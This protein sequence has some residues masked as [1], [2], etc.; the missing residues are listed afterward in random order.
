MRPFLLFSALAFFL[1]AFFQGDPNKQK[2]SPWKPR[3]CEDPC[4]SCRIDSMERETRWG[5]ATPAQYESFK[6]DELL[7]I[8]SK[9]NSCDTCGVER[10][11]GNWCAPRHIDFRE[12]SGEWS[13]W[14]IEQQ[15]NGKKCDILPGSEKLLFKVTAPEQANADRE[16]F[17]FLSTIQQDDILPFEDKFYKW[18][19]KEFKVDLISGYADESIYPEKCIHGGDL[20][21]CPDFAYLQDSQNMIRNLSY[22]FCSVVP[23]TNN[24]WLVSQKNGL[25]RID[26]MSAQWF[27]KEFML[28]EFKTEK[29]NEWMSA[30]HHLSLL[31]TFDPTLSIKSNIKK[32]KFIVRFQV[33]GQSYELGI[34]PGGYYLPIESG[35]FSTLLT[36]KLMFAMSASRQNQALWRKLLA[37]WLEGKAESRIADFI[38]NAWARTD[39]PLDAVGNQTTEAGIDQALSGALTGSTALDVLVRTGQGVHQIWRNGSTKPDSLPASENAFN[40]GSRF[41]RLL[42]LADP[43]LKIL[44]ENTD[45]DKLVFLYKANT[46]TLWSWV[47]PPRA[48]LRQ[49]RLLKGENVMLYSGVP[50]QPY[51]ARLFKSVSDPEKAFLLRFADN[52]DQFQLVDW[53]AWSDMAHVVL[54]KI[55]GE[56]PP[57]PGTQKIHRLS[58]QNGP[59]LQPV[60][61]RTVEIAWTDMPSAYVEWKRKALAEAIFSNAAPEQVEIWVSRDGLGFS[62]KE[63]LLLLDVYPSENCRFT[64]IPMAKIEHYITDALY[65]GPDYPDRRALF[66]VWLSNRWDRKNWRANPRGL[67]ARM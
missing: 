57:D 6:N 24:V 19:K 26:Q 11:G 59:D 52:P 32:Y 37:D 56:A 18:Q 65:I 22:E 42:A 23:G 14:K 48:P 30:L 3:P 16:P 47:G 40:S 17:K 4:S 34:Y 5:R 35:A 1:S 46:Q 51:I 38:P 28:R 2:P 62:R 60:L 36:R 31:A 54:Y 44:A 9:C 10:E 45:D 7:R 25:R 33:E 21:K 58:S 27:K 8:R 63:G 15:K 50:I 49:F 29:S 55:A 67:L 66:Y 61:F 20:R 43:G 12:S 13:F 41:T 64:R 39:N 53:Y